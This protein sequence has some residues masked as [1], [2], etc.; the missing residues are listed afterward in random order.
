MFLLQKWSTPRKIVYIVSIEN[1]KRNGN[2]SITVSP[3]SE[4]IK[5]SMI[6]K[7]KRADEQYI[8]TQ[9]HKILQ[10]VIGTGRKI[11]GSTSQRTLRAGKKI[12]CSKQKLYRKN[13]HK[14]Q[15]IRKLPTHR[16]D[17]QGRNCTYR[18]HISSTKGRNANKLCFTENSRKQWRIGNLYVTENVTNKQKGNLCAR[19]QNWILCLL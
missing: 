3:N 14:G 19:V 12:I 15:E 17:S 16:K 6:C 13:S 5:Q 10:S 7:E 18:E 4:V 11:S 8:R 9:L 1:N 2:N